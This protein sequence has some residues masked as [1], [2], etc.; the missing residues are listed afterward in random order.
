MTEFF[1]HMGMHKT[2][3]T[4]IQAALARNRQRLRK[5]GVLYPL[6][7]L[8]SAG[9]HLLAWGLT[10]NPDSFPLWET[11]RDEIARDG[12]ER[13]VL[14]SEEFEACRHS[15]HWLKIVDALGRKPTVICYVRRQSDY[16][17]SSYNQHIK[18]GHFHSF[19][20]HVPK[21]MPRLDY[22]SKLR[23][24][25]DVVGRDRIILRTYERSRLPEGVVPDFLASIGLD[26]GGFVLGP[27]EI[28]PSLSARGLRI[29]Q[30]LNELIKDKEV[31]RKVSAVILYMHP[32]QSD[33]DRPV[34]MDEAE[35]RNFDARFLRANQEVARRYLERDYLFSAEMD[36]TDRPAS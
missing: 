7:G 10:R 33:S 28:N 19:A 25:E 18:N 1:L 22:L 30:R 36:P 12:A 17:I 26:A 11:L 16:L 3:T 23:M 21:M 4:A 34:L 29:M 6:T 13:V 27:R 15:H 20:E 8:Q 14:S 24:I 32:V 2:G 31:R 35:R 9:H 5:K